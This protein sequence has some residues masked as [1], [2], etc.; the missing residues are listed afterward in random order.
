MS[1]IA[2]YL[3]NKTVSRALCLNAVHCDSSVS[4]LRLLSASNRYTS[5]VFNIAR[6]CFIY[7]KI[8]VSCR[9]KDFSSSYFEPHFVISP[10]HRC[11]GADQVK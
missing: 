2:G 6:H 10:M 1:I 9:A 4:T 5:F 11:V 3:A 7:Q 8:K